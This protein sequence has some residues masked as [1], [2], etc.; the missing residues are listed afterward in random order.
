MNIIVYYIILL[1]VLVSCIK[2]ETN[3]KKNENG[4]E[5]MA[6]FNKKDTV[7]TIEYINKTDTNYFFIGNRFS[8]VDK[9]NSCY[10][11]YPVLSRK[12]NKLEGYETL[13][14]F[15]KI[16]GS[17][18][19]LSMITLNKKIDSIYPSRC[20]YVPENNYGIGNDSIL[21][22]LFEGICI[23]KKSKVALLYKFDYNGD[24]LNNQF[25]Y[26]VRSE[27]SRSSVLQNRLKAFEN[28]KLKGYY[29]YKKDIYIRDTL[30]VKY[31]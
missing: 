23:N 12:I 31:D 27:M 28:I 24:A 19:L 8:F 7:L 15:Y 5:M 13:F 16:E 22:C 29:P 9:R 20:N 17:Y 10:F 1:L 11:L 25:E 26:A 3:T 2:K 21:I 14:G 4:I 30:K 6:T 18:D